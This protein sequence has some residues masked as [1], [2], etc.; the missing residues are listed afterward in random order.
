MYMDSQASPPRLTIRD[1][2]ALSTFWFS[3][4]AQS[5]ALFPIVIPLQILLFLPSG[6]V[7]NAQQALLLGW[8]STV[9]A[10]VS[11]IMPPLFGMASDRTTSR[12]GRRRPYIVAGTLLL[13]LGALLLAAAGNVLIFLLG[14]VIWQVGSNA[15]NAAY[16]SLL[17]DRVPREQRGAASGY[18]GLMTILGNVGSLALAG[19]LLSSVSLT[20]IGSLSI[21]R[22]A[23][24]FYAL[25]SVAL[26]GRVFI[27]RGGVPDEPLTLT[28]SAAAGSAAE[29]G[30]RQRF[31]HLWIAPWR[32]NNFTW[33]FLTR[34]F[35]MLGR[36]LV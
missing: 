24:V 32:H 30:T 2:L 34:A 33:V 25:T 3:L 28:P 27:T 35:V 36:T 13:I 8:I 10:V 11:L 4:N 9:G 1:Q 6:Q 5:A 14:L 15:A 21:E 20:S 18:L 31:A 7:G 19:I 12:F 23:N 26:L 17:P 16:Q 22:G 29:T